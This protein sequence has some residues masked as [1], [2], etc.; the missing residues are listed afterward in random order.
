MRVGGPH[1]GALVVSTE[2]ATVL[3]TADLS[4]AVA[5]VGSNAIRQVDL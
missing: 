1:V 3:E 5:W 2:W 4:Q